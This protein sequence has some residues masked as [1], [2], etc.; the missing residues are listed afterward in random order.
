MGSRQQRRRIEIRIFAEL[1]D[2]LGDLVGMRLF[3]VGVFQELGRNEFRANAVSRVVV[4][5]VAQ[6]ADDFRG[7]RRIQQFDDG[8][9]VRLRV[10]RR[11]RA[12]HHL[13]ARTRAQRAQI[14]NEGVVPGRGGLRFEIGFHDFTSP[15]ARGA[16]TC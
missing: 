15:C 11:D 4:S 9:A 8:L 2:A 1:H 3:L 7:E 13:F 14:G 16:G 12:L 10:A 5:L 6:H